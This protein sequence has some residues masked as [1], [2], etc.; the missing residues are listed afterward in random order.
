M[1]HRSLATVLSL[2]APLGL[3]AAPPP[4]RPLSPSGLSATT[5]TNRELEALPTSRDPWEI[6]RFGG[7]DDRMREPKPAPSG[8]TRTV[9]FH[10]EGVRSLAAAI[11]TLVCRH[12]LF[13]NYEEAPWVAEQ[14]VQELPSP[15]RLETSTDGG[16]P[17]PSRPPVR[18]PASERLD[19]EYMEDP[20]TQLPLDAYDLLEDLVEAHSQQGGHGRFRVERLNDGIASIVPS[21]ALDERG[22]WSAIEPVL[23]RKVTLEAQHRTVGSLFDRV[24]AELSEKGP[25]RVD[26]I[27]VPLNAFNL[28]GVE[29]GAY[30]EPARDVLIRALRVL[31]FR[32]YMT[33][34]F[35]P[36]RRMYHLSVVAPQRAELCPRPE[37]GTTSAASSAG[38]SPGD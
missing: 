19:F 20:E 33:L 26:A 15:T 6:I 27:E 25:Y 12:G 7:W 37:V 32:Y 16:V 17:V 14:D 1:R 23:S 31:P 2:L 8:K 21:A 30:D 18:V 4:E 13:L 22:E 28:T 3:A 29:F 34:K 5:V 10:F 9:V 38:R 24:L 11:D 36:M 35:D